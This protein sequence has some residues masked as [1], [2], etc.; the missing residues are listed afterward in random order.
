MSETTGVAPRRRTG[1]AETTQSYSVLTAET[2]IALT[3]NGDERALGELYDR[4]GKLAYG[5]ALRVARDPGL[6]E[7]AV[8]E[9]FLSIWRSAPKFDPARGAARAWV[10]TLTYRRAIDLVD[11]TARRREQATDELPETG[12]P[13]TAD[14]AAQREE[15]QRVRQA[16]ASLPDAQK[17]AL[18]LAYYRGYS[19]SE[20]ATR[21]A[22]PLGTIKTR[23]FSGLARLRLL[24]ATED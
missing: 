6:A 5:L 2:I 20:I 21:L 24:L 12:G 16:L 4:F 14:V 19:Q 22:V 11:R 18:E 13:S 15:Q 9:A 7:D 17:Q 10:A 8:Q 3:A 23:V 1:R